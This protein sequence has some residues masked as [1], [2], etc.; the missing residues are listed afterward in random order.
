MNLEIPYWKNFHLCNNL[1]NMILGET[2]YTKLNNLSKSLICELVDNKSVPRRKRCW[3]VCWPCHMYCLVLVYLRWTEKMWG[4]CG[5]N[6]DIS[7][8]LSI[9]YQH[10]THK[11]PIP[12]TGCGQNDD[13]G[14]GRMLM[15]VWAKC[16]CGK[17]V[18]VQ[19][20]YDVE[21]KY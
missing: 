12:T 21:T 3:Y 19:I 4:K 17:N 20:I 5:G 11:P 15:W 1:W 7:H 9:S 13:V 16:W 6:Q 18:D 8:I 10:F 2:A 14:V